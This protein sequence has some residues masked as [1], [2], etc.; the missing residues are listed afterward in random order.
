MRPRSG[1]PLE[2]GASDRGRTQVG[3]S[4][5]A[6]HLRPATQR[7]ASPKSRE[8]Y[9]RGGVLSSII[10]NGLGI[11]SNG[12]KVKI[13]S[14]NSEG[15]GSRPDARDTIEP[16]VGGRMKRFVCVLLF[17]FF[18]PLS[19]TKPR[20]WQTATVL[21]AVSNGSETEAVAVPL[22][23]GGAVGESTTT[24][25]KHMHGVYWIKTDKFT[26]V[27][28]NYA[29]AN[30]VGIQWWLY[31]TVGGQVKISIDS[32][33]TMHVIDDEGKDRKVHIIQRMLNEPQKPT[34]EEH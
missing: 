34:Q 27:I 15:C 6:E 28:P 14:L 11:R 2:N 3:G 7:R 20:E 32:V 25:G 22:P 26:Y 31:L 24:S 9:H 12:G 16:K 8:E 29:K 5:P 18:V 10:I 30:M 4:A 1:A 21:K 33:R 13:R 19:I 23:G 17:L